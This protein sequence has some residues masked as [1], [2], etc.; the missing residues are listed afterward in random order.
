M[1]LIT[2]SRVVFTVDSHTQGEPTRFVVGGII[3]FPGET[4]RE[5]QRFASSEL[6]TIRK[7]LMGE[8]RGHIDMYGGFI[9][10]PAT[11][12]GDLGI[13]FMDNYGL[14]DMCGHGT[15]GLCTAVVELGMIAAT[16]PKTKIEI[17]TPVGRVTGFAFSEDGRVKRATF[18]GVPSFCTHIDA[19]LTLNGVGKIKVGIAYGGNLFVVVPAESVKLDLGMHNSH[20]IREMGMKIKDA[21]NEQYDIRHPDLTEVAG[22]NIVTFFGPP[23]NP[24][25]TYKNVHVFSN[26]QIDRSPGGTGTSAMLAYMFKKGDNDGNQD[27]TVEGFAGGLF[28]GRIVD[29]WKDNGLTMH[30]PAIS[31]S[32]FITGFNQFV[33]DSNDPM[34]EG[35]LVG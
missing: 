7:S 3:H 23:V 11:D 31:G 4:M 5:K 9:T 33:L 14:M 19:D 28:N 30:R 21:V 8:P 24:E 20:L 13:L 2:N 22:V 35:F 32:A 16:P 25:A 1:G 6:E 34:S 27:V 29:T 26:G 12:T 15:I 17:D 10:A 18:L